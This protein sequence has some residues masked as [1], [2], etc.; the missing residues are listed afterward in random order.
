MATLVM[1]E[2]EDTKQVT[3]PWPPQYNRTHRYI[4]TWLVGCLQP[5]N[6]TKEVKR[7]VA[8]CSVGISDRWNGSG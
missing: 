2:L 7:K 1:N 4:V 6:N 5:T 3:I 8:S